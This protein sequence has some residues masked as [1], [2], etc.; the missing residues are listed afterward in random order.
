MVSATETLLDRTQ[1]N[2]GGRQGKEPVGEVAP[3]HRLPS[4]VM[5]SAQV[6]PI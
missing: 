1:L 5:V 3:Y 6:S 2:L 4:V